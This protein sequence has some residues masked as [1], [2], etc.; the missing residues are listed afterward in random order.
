MK[1]LMFLALYFWLSGQL[2]AQAPNW[3]WAKSSAGSGS[4]YGNVIASDKSGN[5]VMAGNFYSSSVSI[6]TITVS[7]LGPLNTQD[8]FI[9]KYDGNG[10][11]LW[12]K[13][14]GGAGYD[15]C[16]CI[17]T[18]ANSNIILIGR[19]SSPT[20]S[21]GTTTLTN[22]GGRDVFLMKFD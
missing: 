8:I 20:I 14:M 12:A 19:Y 15:E 17:I 1:K 4:K 21:L 9:A 16:A 22:A 18:D 11:V 10:N 6:G 5:V 2:Y 3:L 13:S 7:N